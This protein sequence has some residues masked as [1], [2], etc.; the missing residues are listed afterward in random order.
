[1]ARM[2]VTLKIMPESEEVN[3]EELGENISKIIKK[4]EGEVGKTETEPIAFGLKA[5]KLTFVI[6]ESKGTEEI[7]DKVSM[8][9]GVSSAQVVDMRRTLG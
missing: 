6:D 4:F 3:L 2:V 5:L 9:E 8:I 7:T 1:M